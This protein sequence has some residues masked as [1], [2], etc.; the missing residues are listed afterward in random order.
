MPARLLFLS[1]TLP[2]PP[3][4]GVKIRS[5]H[6]MRIL[7]RSFEITALCFYRRR[8]TAE[9]GVDVAVRALSE[10]GSVEAFA[11]PQ[12]WSRPRWI[13]DHV[14]S[15]AG[16]APYTDFVFD[17]APFASRLSEVL[18]DQDFDLVHLESS[19]LAGHAMALDDLPRV[20]VHHNVESQLLER[21]ADVASNAASAAYI[22]L[23][24]GRVRAR[25]KEICP[26]MDLNI[27]VS[28]EDADTLRRMAPGSRVTTIPNGVDTHSFEPGMVP[29]EGIALLGGTDWFPN[30]DGLEFFAEEVLP[31]I[32]RSRPDVRV[33]SIGRASQQEIAAFRQRHGIEL[34]GYVDDIRPFV[35][36][37][38]CV[39]V[40]LRVG[41]GSRLK[42]LDSWAMAK[43]IVTTS[44]GC[45]GLD[46]VD[47][48]N[49]LVRDDPPG[50]AEA[51]VR[52]LDD[53]Q[54]ARSIGAAARH[55]AVTRHSW[56]V[57]GERMLT[58]Y[59]SVLGKVGQT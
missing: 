7:A 52:L 26:A 54:L 55:E 30:L 56:D 37:A 29:T 5:F 34:T 18:H 10:L 6:T 24:A 15:L 57:L 9:N 43:P 42:I 44:I 47:G 2:F 14:L 49:A 53:E 46:A 59:Q 35:Q 8:Q 22:R 51:V 4:S 45:E 48:R 40:P 19:A 20:C 41:G 32:R 38:R 33:T 50:L 3:D 58:A 31:L 25:E 16:G 39:V 17:S 23:Q 13:K 11:I 28:D 12:E 27:A 1:Q 21:R 36:R